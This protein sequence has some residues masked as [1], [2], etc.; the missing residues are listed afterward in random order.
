M[1]FSYIS[2]LDG[3]TGSFQPLPPSSAAPGTKQGIS[4]RAFASGS[5]PENSKKFNRPTVGCQP[6]AGWMSKADFFGWPPKNLAYK[7]GRWEG[8]W[9][10]ILKVQ[11]FVIYWIFDM[12]F[13][14]SRLVERLGWMHFRIE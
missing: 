2:H 4:T 3:G 10:H 9:T 8:R 11:E 6:P 14:R 1:F 7:I 12:Y 5:S 13:G